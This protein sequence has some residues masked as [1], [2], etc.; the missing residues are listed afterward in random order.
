MPLGS[1]L[2]RPW[3]SASSPPSPSCGASSRRSPGRWRPTRGDCQQDDFLG[4]LWPLASLCCLHPLHSSS[5][6]LHLQVL[7]LNNIG[8]T[9]HELINDLLNFIARWLYSVCH[10][11]D[12]DLDRDISIVAS[13]TKHCIFAGTWWVALL[14]LPPLPHPEVLDSEKLC[15]WDT[16]RN[17]ASD[18]KDI[19]CFL[20]P[21]YVTYD[22][23]QIK[24]I[25]TATSLMRISNVVLKS[26]P[27][28]ESMMAGGPGRVGLLGRVVGPVL[29]EVGGLPFYLLYSYVKLS[30]VTGPRWGR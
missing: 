20:D 11:S 25:V 19:I 5:Q 22:S 26:V 13:G 2:P 16:T 4:D 12:L 18:E 28:A 15:W 24:W 30:W 17:L 10:L 8:T 6:L 1:S 21:K 9:W 29:V 23:L 3:L 27:Q 14:V 7:V